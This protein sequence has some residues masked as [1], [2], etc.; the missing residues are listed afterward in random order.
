MKDSSVNLTS[1]DLPTTDS[2]LH[3]IQSDVA[4]QDQNG[5]WSLELRCGNFTF[6]DHPPFDVEWQ[7]PTGRTITGTSYENGHFTLLL[8]AP[9]EGGD[10]V[11]G[12]PRQSSHLACLDENSP[13]REATLHVDGM[14]ARML[15]LEAQQA[16]LQKEHDV[17]K[18]EQGRLRGSNTSLTSHVLGIE[19]KL[20]EF[21]STLGKRLDDIQYLDNLTRQHVHFHARNLWNTSTPPF[22]H[23]TLV[24]SNVTANEGSCYNSATGK[25]RTPMDGTYFFAATTGLQTANASS[26]FALLIDGL[27]VALSTTRNVG[28]ETQLGTVHGVVHLKHR[29]DVWLR[30]LDNLVDYY[31]PGTTFTGFL[32][33][34]DAPGYDAPFSFDAYGKL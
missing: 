10:Y 32:L 22:G 8:S 30:S 34:P 18:A 23:I 1:A 13:K 2:A 33:Y 28:H 9:V 5:R 14:D 19:S 6:P 26:M 17:R 24:L 4:V 7:I 25:F 29:Q 15:I 27:V 11:C 21:N 20:Q 12:I 31:A 3:V 16:A